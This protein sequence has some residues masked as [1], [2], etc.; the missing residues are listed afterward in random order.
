MTLREIAGVARMS[1][2]H[3]ARS[4]KAAT[5]LS[6]YQYVIHKRVQLAKNPLAETELAISDVA[7]ATG[8]STSSHLATHVRRLLGVSPKALRQSATR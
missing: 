1:P 3:F 5:G 7:V 2:D 6:P 4:F 8:F